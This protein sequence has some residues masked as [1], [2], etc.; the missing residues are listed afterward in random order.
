VNVG[1]RLSSQALSAARGLVGQRFFNEW[2]PRLGF[3]WR[4]GAGENQR[5]L[6]GSFGRFYEQEALW[7][8]GLF[9]DRWFGQRFFSSDPR[10]PASR[11][12]SSSVDTT[13]FKPTL[14][15]ANVPDIA[16]ENSNELNARLRNGSLDRR[17]SPRA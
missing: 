14:A 12:D 6:F 10:L 11:P 4:P 1:L 13:F 2:Q 17:S 15:N 7:L 3:V 5:V 8:S 16:V 9:G